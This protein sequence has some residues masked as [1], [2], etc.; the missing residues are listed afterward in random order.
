[1]GGHPLTVALGLTN[2]SSGSR[3]CGEPVYLATLHAPFPDTN[4]PLNG[5]RTMEPAVPAKLVDGAKCDVFAGTHK[6]K[7]GVVRDIKTGKSGQV[8]ITVVQANGIRFKTLAKS[9]RIKP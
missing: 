6:G 8:S 1:V 2:K 7:S 3:Y 9:V 4:P 5:E